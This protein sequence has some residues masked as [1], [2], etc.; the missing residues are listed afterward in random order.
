[1]DTSISYSASVYIIVLVVLYNYSSISVTGNV[2]CLWLF[3]Y[4]INIG[5]DL[6]L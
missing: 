2:Y 3:I 4:F 5:N 1:M 6:Y